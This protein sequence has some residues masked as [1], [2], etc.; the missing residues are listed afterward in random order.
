[1]NDLAP[2]LIELIVNNCDI[3]SILTSIEVNK[4][5]KTIGLN[6]NVWSKMCD[7]L[8]L[9]DSNVFLF[10]CEEINKIQITDN[11]EKFCG[12]ITRIRFSSNIKA[13]QL[14]SYMLSLLKRIPRDE[15]LVYIDMFVNVPTGLFN[16][17]YL[18]EYWSNDCKNQTS[19]KFCF[20]EKLPLNDYCLK[21]LKKYLPYNTIQIEDIFCRLDWL[22][23]YIIISSTDEILRCPVNNFIFKKEKNKTL[24]IL[25]RFEND[26]IRYLSDDD[27]KLAKE[28]YIDSEIKYVIN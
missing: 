18:L 23:N 14:L 5:F 25:F 7:R 4:Q 8:D 16:F 21:C 13:I 24:R 28:L 22:N 1:M 9:F 19:K 26:E 15:A 11:Y 10:Y 27:I 6:L 2:E 12:L 3:N 17:I 20:E